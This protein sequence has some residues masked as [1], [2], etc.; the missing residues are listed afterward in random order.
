MPMSM[1][2]PTARPTK[3]ASPGEARGLVDTG[4]LV[5]LLGNSADAAA[6][7]AAAESISG[8][9]VAK[10]PET[11]LVKA[12]INCSYQE[13]TELVGQFGDPNQLDPTQDPLLTA[14][15]SPAE[16]GRASSAR[17]RR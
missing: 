9:K 13:T 10:L 7:M 5:T 11:E 15:I 14:I 4:Q 1:F 17:P 6:V 16:L 3:V 2:D 8:N 12:L